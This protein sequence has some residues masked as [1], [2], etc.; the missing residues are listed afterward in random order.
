M[1]NKNAKCSHRGAPK[2]D[3]KEITDAA[4]QRRPELDYVETAEI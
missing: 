4:E 1:E 2:R 3:R